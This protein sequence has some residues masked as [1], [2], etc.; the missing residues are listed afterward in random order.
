LLYTNLKVRYDE[1]FISIIRPLAVGFFNN[2]YADACKLIQSQLMRYSMD[3]SKVS[4]IEKI[5]TL[6]PSGKQGVNID[7]FKYDIMRDCIIKIITEQEQIT[8]G[9][10]GDRV[11]SELG[12][13]SSKEKLAGT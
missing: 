6:N 4:A 3:M 1:F 9:E 10:L 5:M 12:G 11:R 13:A 2:Q 7:K 8:L